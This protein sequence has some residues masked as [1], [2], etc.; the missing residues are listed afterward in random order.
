MAQADRPTMHNPITGSAQQVWASGSFLLHDLKVLCELQYL[1]KMS[2]LQKKRPPV[3]FS[4]SLPCKANFGVLFLHLR[5][6][7]AETKWGVFNTCE[8]VSEANEATEFLI[9]EAGIWNI[10]IP[11][12]CGSKIHFSIYA[13]SKCTFSF[14]FGIPCKLPGYKACNWTV[15]L[16]VLEV[17]TVNPDANSSLF[18][19]VWDINTSKITL[20]YTAGDKNAHTRC[21]LTWYISSEWQHFILWTTYTN[22]T[23]CEWNNVTP[24]LPL[25]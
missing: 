4:G 23:N 16:L 19:R 13:I 18:S 21:A 11:K 3:S 24:F 7:I 5:D 6:C 25:F 9:P 14:G 15:I 20:F 8:G 17:A 12:Y 2:V 10:F 22:C 1:C